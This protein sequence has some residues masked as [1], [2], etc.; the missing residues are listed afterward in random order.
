[1]NTATKITRKQAAPILSR[2]FPDYKG[3]TIR[4]EFTETMTFSDTNWGGGS[5]SYYEAIRSDGKHER[6]P[7]FSPWNNPA[8]GRRIPLTPDV[9]IV[10]H[11][12]FCGKD[13]GITIYANPSHQPKWIAAPAS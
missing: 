3:R 7:N 11:S 8:E 6:L 2:S 5:R 4:V 13:C 12:I 10:E 9:L 1:M